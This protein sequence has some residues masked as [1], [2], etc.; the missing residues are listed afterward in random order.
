[1]DVSCLLT[2]PLTGV[3][4]Y[5]RYL[6]EALA[7]LD[8][9]LHLFAASARA[10]RGAL[11]GLGQDALVKRWPT[12]LRI[13]M[14]TA[15]EWPPLEWFTG[16]VDIVHGMFHLLPPSKGVPR[17][18]TVFDLTNLRCAD[19]HTAS[20]N[21]MH[22]TMLTH[23]ARRADGVIAI[24]ESCKRDVVELLD[25]APEK[26][27][28]VYGGIVPDEFEGALDE[29]RVSALRRQFEIEGDYF[30]HLGTIEPRKN[31]VRLLEAYGRVREVRRDCPVLVL[32]GS[33]GWKSEP[34]YDAIAEFGLEECVRV[35]GYLER[36]DAVL[37]LREAFGCLYPSLYEGFGLPVLE[38]MAARV[39]VLT[40]TVSSLPEV[41]GDTG[42]LVDPADVDEIAAGITELLENETA[43]DERVGKAY[44]RSKRFS[45]AASAGRLAEIYR[46]FAR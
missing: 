7:A 8:V 28:V 25:I 5:T 10:D 16:A 4:Y 46:K 26:V 14:W 29:K 43:R 32:A 20:S 13:A 34:V 42:I 1:M 31:L 9:E 44:E 40:S 23:A 41:V 35:T 17:L 12:R 15:L 6:V 36:G 22:R 11:A 38:A 3:G 45:W 2:R 21:R 19:T 39:P 24:S 33:R 30:I 37:L 27:H 18:T